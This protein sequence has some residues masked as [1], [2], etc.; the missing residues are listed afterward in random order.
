[1]VFPKILKN[2]IQTKNKK[3]FIDDM[4]P[5]M[6]SYK[7][8]S[9]ILNWLFFRGRKLNISLIFTTQSYFDVQKILE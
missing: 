4:I 2:T 5:E 6:L 9:P 8:L 7:K 3:L 1:M